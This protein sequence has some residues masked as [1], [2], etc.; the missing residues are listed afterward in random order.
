MTQA[1]PILLV[2]TIPFIC[3]LGLH[4]LVLL[5]VDGGV[6]QLIPIT[7]GLWMRVGKA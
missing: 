2:Y 5:L 6:W 4:L 1:S 7:Q 3:G